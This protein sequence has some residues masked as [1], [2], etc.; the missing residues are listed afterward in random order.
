M[1]ST[2]VGRLGRA[3]RTAPADQAQPD[4]SCIRGSDRPDARTGA[5]RY[6]IRAGCPARG[7]AGATGRNGTLRRVHRRALAQRTT[8][9]TSIA[10]SPEQFVPAGHPDLLP[11]KLSVRTDEKI[12]RIAAHAEP[13]GDLQR[14]GEVFD[15]LRI[16]AVAEQEPHRN[17]RRAQ[18]VN[19]L[20]I[21][22]QTAGLVGTAKSTIVPDI[23]EERLTALP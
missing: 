1:G 12:G 5:R 2:S 7:E 23:D 17:G 10:Q 13:I 18:C 6:E 8:A 9:L 16:D 3:C 21:S 4:R 14:I 22:Q 11:Q 20:G 15:V 19:D